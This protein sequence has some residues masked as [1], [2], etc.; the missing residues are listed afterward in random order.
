MKT[1]L[2][3]KETIHY[4]IIISCTIFPMP[5]AIKIPAAKAA[6]DKEWEKLEKIPAWDLTKVRTKK[7]VIDEARTKGAKA[8]FA[9]LMDSCHLKNAELETKD[10]KYK[11]RVVLRGDIVKDDSSRLP[12]CDG[13]A[14]DAVSAYTQV[15]M[16][17]APKLWKFPNRNIQTFGFV[18]HDTNVLNHG[19]VWKTQSFLLN[20]ICAVILWQDFYGTGNLR[21]ILLKHG[22]RKFQI[23]NVSLY[24]VKKDFSYLCMWMT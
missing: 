10:Q 12:G 14:A 5:Q 24:I 15:K 1:I 23:G 9:S 22:W 8:H 6:V 18:Y 3:E 7:E 11:G 21:K 13:Q 19:P 20:A 2:Q 4:S 17:D 16:E